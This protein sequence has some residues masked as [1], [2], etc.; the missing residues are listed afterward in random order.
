MAL[1]DDAKFVHANCDRIDIQTYCQHFP[2]SLKQAKVF[3]CTTYSNLKSALGEVAEEAYYELS[4]ETGTLYLIYLI[5]MEGYLS[6]TPFWGKRVEKST[7]KAVYRI[8][9]SSIEHAYNVSARY[10]R[11]LLKHEPTDGQVTIACAIRE[12]SHELIDLFATFDIKHQTRILKRVDED[13]GEKKHW[14]ISP[15]RMAMI[16]EI[17]KE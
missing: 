10:I 7:R 2:S 12:I 3:E 16:F 4:K 9:S 17:T 15:E 13:L 1:Q 6:E 8:V 14:M 5:R 11:A